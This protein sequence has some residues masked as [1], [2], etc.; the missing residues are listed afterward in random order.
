MITRYMIATAQRNK[1]SKPWLKTEEVSCSKKTA[2]ESSL[3]VKRRILV[4]AFWN[5]FRDSTCDPKDTYP[6]ATVPA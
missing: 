1:A 3:K 4:K 6:D 5:V 2:K